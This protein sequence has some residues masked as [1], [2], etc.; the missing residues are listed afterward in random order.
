MTVNKIMSE[1]AISDIVRERAL[2]DVPR[3]RRCLRCDTVFW[4][5]GFGERICWRCK[6]LKA[7]R[8]AV[9]DSPGASRR[10]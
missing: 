10:R 7:W 2:G 8:N 4:S 5:D 6:K 3:E 9:P 1:A